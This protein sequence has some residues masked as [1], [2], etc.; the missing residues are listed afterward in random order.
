[1]SSLDRPDRC[2]RARGWRRQATKAPEPWRLVTSPSA[3]NAAT[4]RAPPCGSR[5]SPSSAPAPWALRIFSVSAPPPPRSNCAEAE[6]GAAEHACRAGARRLGS[7]VVGSSYHMA[8]TVDGIHRDHALL[9][10]PLRP[11]YGTLSLDRR[12]TCRALRA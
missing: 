2:G 6:A 3:R 7:V 4:L 12:G 1:Q 8:S 10:P 5:P 11:L 9:A